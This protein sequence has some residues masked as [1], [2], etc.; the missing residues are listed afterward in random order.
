MNGEENF[1]LID[2][3]NIN[4]YLNIDIKD[5]VDGSYEIRKLYLIKRIIDK[6][7]LESVN[8]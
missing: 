1:E 7:E 6:L 8:S 5:Y 4:K 3:G 2:K